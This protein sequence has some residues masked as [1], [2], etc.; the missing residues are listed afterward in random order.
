[1]TAPPSY[2]MPLRLLKLAMKA[3][4]VP[5]V[6][7]IGR[8][9]IGLVGAFVLWPVASGLRDPAALSLTDYVGLV[10]FS[11]VGGWLVLM[12]LRGRG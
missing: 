6:T 9:L 8:V 3:K 1:M 10:V 2:A 4:D 7:I 12:A 11:A 5:E